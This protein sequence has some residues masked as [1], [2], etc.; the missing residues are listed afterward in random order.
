MGQVW[1]VNHLNF[2]IIDDRNSWI[3]KERHLIDQCSSEDFLIELRN[4]LTK[5]EVVS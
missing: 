1:L 5:T 3:G 4:N 2:K